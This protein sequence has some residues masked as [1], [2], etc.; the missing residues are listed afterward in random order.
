MNH[1]ELRILCFGICLTFSFFFSISTHSQTVESDERALLNV[2]ESEGISF[3][4]DSLFLMNLRFRMQNRAGFNTLEGD[5]FEVSEYEMRVRRLRLR[6]DGFVGNPRFQYYIQLAFSKADLD[7][8][9]SLVAQPIRDAILYYF[10]NE[11]L[12]IG[13]GQSKLPGNRQRV[14]S[15]G[16]LQFADRSTANAI[17]TLDRDFGFFLYKTIPFKNQSILQLKGVVSTGDGRN[18]S[19][20]NDG[21]AYTGRIE[22]LPFGRFSNS[23]DYSEGDFEFEPKPKLALGL[24]LS[25]NQK[26][27]RTGGQLGQELFDARNMNSFIVDG[28][29]KHMGWAVMG[30]YL[31]R[32]SN[33]P[34]TVDELGEIRYVLVGWGFNTQISKMLDRKNELAVRYANVTPNAQINQFQQRVD[35]ALLGFT[36]YVNGHRIKIQ[37]NLGYKWLEGLAKFENTGNSWTGMFQVEFGI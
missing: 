21:L 13:F 24:T 4:K 29:Y 17:F 5:A 23:G 15:S 25:E 19:A 34:I 16:N 22:Y 6:F 28:I 27:T 10:I 35:E 30:E 20:I 31:H 3:S 2:G 14:I 36:H 37:A 1:Y 26:A 18:A 32:S 11:N 12:Y 33:D 8:E 9:T 7:L